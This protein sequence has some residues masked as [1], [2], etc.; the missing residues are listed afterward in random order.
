M[1]VL[2]NCLNIRADVSNE[3][4]DEPILSPKDQRAEKILR[5]LP[6]DFIMIEPYHG[7]GNRLRAFGSAAALARKTGKTLVVI[8]IQDPHVNAT[9]QDLFDTTNITVIDYPVTSALSRVFPEILSYDYNS[10]GRKDEILRDSASLPIYVRSA[11]VLQSETPISEAD[12]SEELLSL[13][14]SREVQ[15][16]ISILEEKIAK[17]KSNMIGVH[18]RMN[19]DITKD[20]PGIQNIDTHSPASAKHMGPVISERAR[21]NYKAFIPHMERV[22]EKMPQ[23]SFFIASDSSCAIL[24][25]ISKFPGKVLSTDLHKLAVCEGSTS[26]GKNCLQMSLSEFWVLGSSVSYLILSEWSSASE[27][28]LR[29]G[30]YKVPHETGCLPRKR[31]FFGFLG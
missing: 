27:L 11:Y 20:V 31:S 3:L 2:V 6:R 16:K 12:I 14:P 1:V 30:A 7:L 22:L 4:A 10:K 21:C 13:I 9:M 18:V 29:L 24:S 26:R 17:N 25:L 8:W 28:I 19:T 5:Q 15:E 23:A